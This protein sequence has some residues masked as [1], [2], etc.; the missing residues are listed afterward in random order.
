MRLIIRRDTPLHVAAR[1]G[2]TEMIELLLKIKGIEFNKANND[3]VTPL[4]YAAY[5]K[6]NLQK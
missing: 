1:V 6:G 4:Y 2:D 3:G 5:K